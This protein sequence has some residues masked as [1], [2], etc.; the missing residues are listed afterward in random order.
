MKRDLLDGDDGVVLV[1]SFE[2]SRGSSSSDEAELLV[3]DSFDL[4]GEGMASTRREQGRQRE[5]TRRV[6]KGRE[7]NERT[8]IVSLSVGEGGRSCCCC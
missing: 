7:G 8:M 3:R 2:D 4:D 1:D 5:G 6:E